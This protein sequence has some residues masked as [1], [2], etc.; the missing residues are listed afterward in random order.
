MH[1]VV[2]LNPHHAA[3]ALEHANPGRHG[4]GHLALQVHTRFGGTV[5]RWFVHAR[6]DA[7]A[8]RCTN[9]PS[10]TLTAFTVEFLGKCFAYRRRE[11]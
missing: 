11:C 7:K 5:Q 4:P 8:R 3:V 1:R 2:E 6:H 9:P 10:A